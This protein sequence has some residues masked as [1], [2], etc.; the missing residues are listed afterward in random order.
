MG[1]NHARVLATM[2][3]VQL[4]GIYDVD[5]AASKA[6]A[7]L[8]KTQSF[9]KLTEIE[10]DDR[11]DACVIATPTI[12]HHA[13]G[14]RLM[15][16]GKHVLIEKPLASDLGK[17]QE[18]ARLADRRGRILAVGHIERHNPIV[19]YLRTA[20]EAGK[21]GD[22]IQAS[23][24]RVSSF[25]GRIRDTGVVLDLAI[26][27]LDVLRYVV[28]ARVDDV[29]A[30]AGT[31]TRGLRYED[32]ATILLRFR[33][34]VTGAVEVN[35]LTPMKI[36]RLA[37]T[38]SRCFVDA[39]YITQ[40]ADIASARLK[41]LREEDAYRPELIVRRTKV[42]VRRQEPLALELADFV[43]ALQGR[44]ARP[45]VNGRDGVEGLRLAQ[46]ALRSARTGR[47]ARP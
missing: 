25:P 42:Q 20:L 11:I 13:L 47:P 26:H 46:A 15:R 45:L 1:K 17:A 37:L 27:D 12:N 22:L 32:H 44:V 19:R 30:A 18:L 14:K 36:R 28:G 29:Y 16:A 39:D 3:G 38:A 5:Q 4:A 40:S 31:Y 21:F 10:R 35:W 41:A 7:A 43:R 2:K 9:A 6:V 33:S 23:T 8:R 24:R 34:G